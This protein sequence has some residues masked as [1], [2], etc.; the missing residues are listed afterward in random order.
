MSTPTTPTD[1]ELIA[2]A[3]R[4]VELGHLIEVTDEW[5]AVQWAALD[6]E[7]GRPSTLT[8]KYHLTKRSPE[9]LAKVRARGCASVELDELGELG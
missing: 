6:A 5:L 3:Q 1:A 8:D 9:V 7:L 4:A 2:A